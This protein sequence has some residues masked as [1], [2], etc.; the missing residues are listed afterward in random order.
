VIDSLLKNGIV[1]TMRTWKYKPG[2]I[3]VIRTDRGTFRGR[4]VDVVPNTL[5]N[6]MKLYRISGFDSADEWLMEAVKLHKKIP[7]YIVVVQIVS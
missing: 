6:R 5:E 2:Q 7:S 4:I 3:V 1:A